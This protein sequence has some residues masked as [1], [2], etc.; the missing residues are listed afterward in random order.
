MVGTNRRSTRQAATRKRSKYYDPDT[1]DDFD[2]DLDA[3][4]EDDYAPEGA[5]QARPAPQQPARKRQRKSRPQTRSRATSRSSSS[6]GKS[7]AAAAAAAA[8]TPRLRDIGKRRRGNSLAAPPT[9]DF[10]GPSDGRIPDWTSLPI[11]ILRQCFVHASRPLLAPSRPSAANVDWLIKTA[12]VCRAFAVPAL[13][14]YYQAPAL[15]TSYAPHHLLALL[16]MPAERRHMNYN[17]KVKRLEI[18]VRRLAYTATHRGLFDVSQLVAQLPLLQGI[19][20]SHPVDEP[21]FRPMKI[22]SW[23]YP[24]DLFDTMERTGVRLRSWRWTRSMIG[25]QDA[26]SM[27]DLMARTH[28]SAAFQN[29]TRLTVC[30]YG[31]DDS[32][33][34]GP[35][36]D[37][38][39]VAPGLASSIALLPNLKDLTFITCEVLEGRFLE[40]L[41]PNLERLEITNCLELT[42][43]MLSSYLKTRGS[44]LRGLVLNH[45]PALNLTFLTGL[46]MLC[47]RLQTLKVDLR[48]YSEKINSN[49]AEPLYQELLSESDIPTWPASLQHLELVHLQRF[50]APAAENLFRSLVD[51]S[52]ALPDLRTLVLHSHIN[53]P[54]R[55]RAEFRDQWIERLQRVFARRSDPPSQHLGSLKQ[56]RLWKAQQDADAELT[57]PGKR[58]RT[59]DGGEEF[60]VGRRFESVHISPRKPHEGE[61]DV[62]S[63]SAPE[64][65]TT[66]RNIRRSGRV[67]AAEASRA[68]GPGASDHT[69]DSEASDDEAEDQYKDAFVQ[70][71]CNVVDIRIDNQRP[72]ENQFTEGDFLD[73]EMSGDEEWREGMDEDIGAMRGSESYAW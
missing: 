4:G 12:K 50:Q 5:P 56:F 58:S 19:E 15:L 69:S 47:P 35:S 13:E 25:L 70:G 46:G 36:E 72:R 45:N 40:R 17:A 38:A 29:I 73:S 7:K 61:T 2:F 14:T 53:I 60:A 34:P 11:E 23:H 48:Y 9:K 20:I 43:D 66:N 65:S 55:Q 1:D 41:P 24:D 31:W 64:K 18:D 51:H 68:T 10:A 27:Y 71:R 22:Q 26:P 33:E 8:A 3:D 67:A 6:K 57:R 32:A 37:G 39:V 21:P 16:Q 42:S 63:D 28:T 49:D 30:G 62:Y 52:A 54:W 59:S 44:H